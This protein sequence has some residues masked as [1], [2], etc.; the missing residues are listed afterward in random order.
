MQASVSLAGR[1]SR[2]SASRSSNYDSSQDVTVAS[3]TATVTALQASITSLQDA[4]TAL[5]AR[6]TT[7]ENTAYAAAGY[8]FP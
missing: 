3:L 8:V 2:L 7:L 6:L 4:H 5:E 1:L